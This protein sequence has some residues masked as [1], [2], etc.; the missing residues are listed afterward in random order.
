MPAQPLLRNDFSDEVDRARRRLDTLRDEHAR[1][2]R[3]LENAAA[4]LDGSA[5]DG[6]TRIRWVATGDRD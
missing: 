3:E 6:G 1:V 5:P 2:C 4:V